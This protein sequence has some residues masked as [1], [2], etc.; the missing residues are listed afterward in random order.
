[1]D[2]LPD[3]RSVLLS[4]GAASL[5]I[6]TGHASPSRFAALESALGGR[7]GVYAMRDGDPTVISNRPNERFAMCSTFKA[8]LAAFI[9]DEIDNG[10]LDPAK[11]LRIDEVP[12]IG[13][14]PEVEPRREQGIRYMSLAGLAHAAVVRSDNTAANILLDQIGG[15]EGFTAKV[16]K[17][18]GST[19][20]DR[21][22]PDLNE[23][24][25]GDPRDTTTPSGMAALMSRLLFQSG[26]SQRAAAT[27]RS[28]MID[29]ATGGKR[30]RAGL[31]QG[32]VVGDKTGTSTNGLY[33]DIAF[34]ETGDGRPP[35]IIAAYV[36]APL[37]DG[38]AGNAAHQEIARIV[39][40]GFGL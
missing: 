11:P 27:V 35:V 33:A 16:R 6:G 23:S 12:L 22:E 37:A 25:P 21:Y 39:A 9:H 32:L 5:A 1:M 17:F 4:V 8:P 24:R 3:R 26:F 14:S 34:V 15:P 29:S 7:V 13:W 19:Q 10:G 18:E 36:D 40:E 38:A 2:T 30:L 20:L 31:P 28:L